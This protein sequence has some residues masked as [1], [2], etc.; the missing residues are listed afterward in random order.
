MTLGELKASLKKAK[1]PAG[2]APALAALW[3][4][5]KDKWDEAHRMVMNEGGKDCAWV[6]AYL[7]RA[8]G[9]LDNARYWY[10][11]ARRSVPAGSLPEEW[12]KIARTLLAAH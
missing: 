12:R 6:H 1:P 10:R 7:H 9:D 2:L 5:G 3:W 4:A 11:Q 8:E